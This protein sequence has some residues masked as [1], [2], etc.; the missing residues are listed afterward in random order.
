MIIKYF[1]I[2]LKLGIQSELVW[3]LLDVI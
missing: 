1:A 2:I 3:D